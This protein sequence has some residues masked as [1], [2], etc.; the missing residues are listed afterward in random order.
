[1]HHALDAVRNDLHVCGYDSS[2]IRQRIVDYMAEF[3][4]HELEA[5][6]G[7]RPKLDIDILSAARRDR[8]SLYREQLRPNGVSVFTTVVWQNRHG[9]FGFHLARTGRGRTFRPQELDALA[10]VLPSI[11]LAEAYLALAEDAAES[12]AHQP[13]DSWTDSMGLS[14]GERAVA[15]LVVRGLQNREIA[16]VLGRSPLTVR[17]QLVSVF[18]KANV[19]SRAELAFL[20]A[21]AERR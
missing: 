3:E 20:I 10:H 21:S 16:A 6:R 4:P 9:M 5:V 14:K 12:I 2:L 13:F 17:N 7:D 11:K 8:L 18:R 19:S 1:M 15:A